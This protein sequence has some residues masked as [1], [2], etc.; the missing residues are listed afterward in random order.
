MKCKE[1]HPLTSRISLKQRISLHRKACWNWII[2]INSPKTV[3][4]VCKK[5]C[6]ETAI[7]KL[8][9]VVGYLYTHKICWRPPKSFC[10]YGLYQ[11]IFTL[12]ET[13]AEKLKLFNSFKMTVRNMLTQIAY[14]RNRCIYSWLPWVLVAARAIFHPGVRAAECL[15]SVVEAR[16]FSCPTLHEGSSYPDQGS[17]SRSLHWNADS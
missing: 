4:G 16:R 7:L 11:L 14:L 3:K 6:C 15:G 12:W 8:F 2:H 1:F 10:L 5:V 17:N 13:Q 9:L